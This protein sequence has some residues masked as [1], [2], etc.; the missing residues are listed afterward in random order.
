MEKARI[1][2]EMYEANNKDKVDENNVP[3]ADAAGIAEGKDIFMQN[4][5]PVMVKLVKEVQGQ[6]LQMITGYT[7]VL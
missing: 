7:K 4:A 2:K 1:E 6:I 3:M 5:G